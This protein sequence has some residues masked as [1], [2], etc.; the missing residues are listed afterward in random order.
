M[1]HIGIFF[2]GTMQKFYDWILLSLQIFAGIKE[3]INEVR[4]I[5]IGF[6]HY[7]NTQLQ[8]KNILNKLNTLFKTYS[9][10]IYRNLQQMRLNG[11]IF[12]STIYG[13]NMTI[14]KIHKLSIIIDAI[15]VGKLQTTS[16]ISLVKLNFS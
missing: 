10:I 12:V 7:F 5:T 3:N 6:F 15:N 4:C 16:L 14:L 1:I 13:F 2:E 11:Y 8:L 9:Y